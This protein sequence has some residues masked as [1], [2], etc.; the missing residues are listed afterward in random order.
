MPE[1]DRP[2]AHPPFDPDAFARESESRIAAAAPVSQVG[3]PISHVDAL[4]Q[5]EDSMLARFGSRSS[6]LVLRVDF[7][8]VTTLA[9]D[10]REGF[11]LS[12]IDGASTVEQILDVCGMPSVEA[13]R[14]LCR[15]A[16][17]GVIAFQ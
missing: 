6:V 15:L 2:T 8:E 5:S 3:P 4:P 7:D 17:E 1:S 9:L 12:L 16:A 14:I 10:H 11:L 13:T